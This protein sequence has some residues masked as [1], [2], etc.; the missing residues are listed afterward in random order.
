MQK[1]LYDISIFAWII[2]NSYLIDFLLLFPRD[3]AAPVAAAASALLAAGPGAESVEGDAG[4]KAWLSR[5]ERDTTERHKTVKQLEEELRRKNELKRLMENIQVH[6]TISSAQKAPQ[7]KLQSIKSKAKEMSSS[8][9][10]SN[11]FLVL[12]GSTYIK[13]LG[14]NPQFV[15]FVGT[16]QT[17]KMST[18]H[19]QMSKWANEQMSRDELSQMIMSD[20]AEFT[21]LNERS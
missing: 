4:R 9:Y 20:R 12:P 1:L 16:L 8:G 18:C 10:Q 11:I 14:F 17:F 19:E 7:D 15:R 13:Y 6:G 3:T 21:T 5:L 2:I